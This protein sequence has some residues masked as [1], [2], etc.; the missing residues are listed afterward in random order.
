MLETEIEENGISYVIPSKTSQLH[1]YLIK[2][3]M[4]DESKY[5]AKEINKEMKKSKRKE[6]LR[7]YYRQIGRAHV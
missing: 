3:I 1:Y 6:I 4:H 7:N 5:P 2:K